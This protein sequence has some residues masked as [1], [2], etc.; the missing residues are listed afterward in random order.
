MYFSHCVSQVT[1]LG[2][3]IHFQKH[4]PV[5]AIPFYPYLSKMYL[6]YFLFSWGHNLAL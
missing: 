5:I 4:A 6:L 2:T 1:F 3:D